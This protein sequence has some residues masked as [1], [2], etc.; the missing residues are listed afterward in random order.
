MNDTEF[1]RWVRDHYEHHLNE[2][3]VVDDEYLPDVMMSAIEPASG[4]DADK[5]TI[6]LAR[7]IRH[8][9]DHL[10][11]GERAEPSEDEDPQQVLPGYEQLHRR[12]KIVRNGKRKTVPIE[13][14]TP[15]ELRGKAL[16]LRSFSRGAQKHADELDRYADER[17][18]Q[19][20][21]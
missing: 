14:M 18:A 12:Y 16:Q 19:A 20:A 3:R 13:Q 5:F 11:R 1:C 2:G 8:E 21:E 9:V 15:A 10:I 17:E 7:A 6:G 4:P